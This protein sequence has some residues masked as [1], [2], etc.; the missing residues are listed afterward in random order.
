MACLPALCFPLVPP[1]LAVSA[2]PRPSDSCNKLLNLLSGSSPQQK[3]DFTHQSHPNCSLHRVGQHL[4]RNVR[5]R[6]T[7]ALRF[8]VT[9]ATGL[10]TLS[11]GCSPFIPWPSSHPCRRG[12]FLV[13]CQPQRLLRAYAFQSQMSG[14]DVRNP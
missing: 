5:D 9:D 4:A 11:V 12:V 14:C 1:L 3:A 13:S 6:P 7:T 10:A 2:A 8:L